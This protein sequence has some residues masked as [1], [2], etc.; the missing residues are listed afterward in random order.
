MIFIVKVAYLK[1]ILKINKIYGGNA[2]PNIAQ[3]Q[4]RNSV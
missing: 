4:S 1:E 2:G 3:I